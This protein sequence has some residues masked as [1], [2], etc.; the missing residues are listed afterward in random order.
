GQK[1]HGITNERRDGVPRKTEDD[2]PRGKHPEQKGFAR[3]LSHA[4]KKGV[5]AKLRKN[6]R[7]KIELSAGHGAADEYHVEMRKHRAQLSI[8]RFNVIPQMQSPGADTL[9]LQR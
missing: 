9:I 4:M 2:R 1:V 5:Q 8:H 6:T 3:L 7:K